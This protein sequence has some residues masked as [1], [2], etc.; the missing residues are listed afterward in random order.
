MFSDKSSPLIRNSIEQSI[1]IY[2]SSFSRASLRQKIRDFRS[3]NFRKLTYSE[4][5]QAICSVLKSENPNTGQG[6][7]WGMPIRYGT[8]SSGT[9][10]YRIRLFIDGENP[11]STVAD[12]WHPPPEVTKIGRVNVAGKPVLYTSPINPTIAAAEMG[13][14]DGTPSVLLE[15][16]A[17]EDVYLGWITYL[18]RFP[19]GTY[20]QAEIE[21]IEMIRDFLVEEFSREVGAGS[22]HLYRITNIIADEYF[23][24]PNSSGYCYPSIARKEGFLNAAFY[25]EQAKEK[26]ELTGISQVRFWDTGET[27]IIAKYEANFRVADNGIDVVHKA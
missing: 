12:C 8:Y 27:H 17:R 19:D 15:F 25:S 22:E 6:I 13:V 2:L 23:N 1:R 24:Y 9:K 7:G 3:L 20:S 14:M 4:L 16:T 10:F 18:N 26:L 5:Q 21:K 11:V